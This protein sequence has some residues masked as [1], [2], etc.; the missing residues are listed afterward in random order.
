[1]RQA[2]LRLRRRAVAPQHGSQLESSGQ[3]ASDD[4]T[5][6]K[7]RSIAIRQRAVSAVP[8]RPCPGERGFQTDSQVAR[9]DREVTAGE[10]PMEGSAQK[11]TA[12]V[13]FFGNNRL[14]VEGLLHDAFALLSLPPAV[15]ET[16]ML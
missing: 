2:D 15:S 14:G 4:N 6:G 1:M 10:A 16:G 7:I 8:P 11:Q 13:V 12:G 9:P 5:S 3:D